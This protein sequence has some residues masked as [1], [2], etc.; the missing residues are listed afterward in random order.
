MFRKLYDW[1]LTLAGRPSA[2]RWLAAVAF[3]DGA[4]FTLPPEL[5]QLPMSIARPTRALRYA[6]VGIVGSAL[7]AVVAYYIGASLYTQVAIPLL[8]FLHR[9]AEFNQFV[10]EVAGNKLL[11]P[12]IFFLAPMPAAIAAGSVPLGLPAT[13]L[14][15][16]VGRGAR[17]L[18]V[19][20]LLKR[21]GGAAGRFIEH[22]FHR[23]AIVALAAIA[24]FVVVRYA[25]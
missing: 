19:A 23:A 10:V 18:I 20:L 14:A 7:G 4:V 25:L 24:G 3:I 13:L 8:R 16:V 12:L 9:E 1:L 15:S 2:E 6:V 22:H 17:F 5:L 21:F 11:W